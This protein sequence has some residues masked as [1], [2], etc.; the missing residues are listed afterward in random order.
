MVSNN[1]NSFYLG[2]YINNDEIFVALSLLLLLIF[3]SLSVFTHTCI[4]LEG[5]Y[6][7]KYVK[8]I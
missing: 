2:V 1:K 6:S 8:L 3:N 5:E 4:Y 7:S